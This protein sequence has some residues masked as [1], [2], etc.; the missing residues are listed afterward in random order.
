M[1]SGTIFKVTAKVLEHNEDRLFELLEALALTSHVGDKARLK[2]IVEEV[3][4][5]W[6]AL[7]FSRGMTVATIRLSSYFSD[8]GRSSEHDQLTYYQ[9]LQDLCAHFE[10]K[11]DRVIENLKTLMSAFFNKD[12]LVM[13]LCCDESHRETA[14]KKMESFVDQLPILP[15]PESQCRSLLHRA[16]MRAL[17]PAARS[18]MFLP[19][20]ISVPMAMTIRAP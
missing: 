8:S 11:A 18:S 10:E 3:K 9:F 15:L 17:R 12:R 1:T 7:F 13:S 5:G 14:E 16:L 4:A 20:A 2:E 19:A 6:D